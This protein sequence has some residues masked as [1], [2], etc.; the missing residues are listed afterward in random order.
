MISC[1]SVGVQ[2]DSPF[3]LAGSNEK[4]KALKASTGKVVGNLAL[5]KDEHDYVMLLSRA[6]LE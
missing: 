4:K 6:C 5:T 2:S 3:A 1:P